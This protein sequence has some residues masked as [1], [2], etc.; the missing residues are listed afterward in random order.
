M[1][2]GVRVFY[3]YPWLSHVYMY[4]LVAL[5][6]S[7]VLCMYMF[8][9]I[10]QNK[11]FL[12]QLNNLFSLT[13]L[14]LIGTLT[15]SESLEIVGRMS[16]TMVVFILKNIYCYFSI[17]SCTKNHYFNRAHELFPQSS[18]ISCKWVWLLAKAKTNTLLYAKVFY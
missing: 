1:F 13:H 2:A 5:V 14:S 12:A 3:R 9:F 7:C 4:H 11:H 16:W 15:K 17:N 6:S 10:F 8:V 18:I